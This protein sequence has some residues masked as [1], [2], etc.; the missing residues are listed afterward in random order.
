MKKPTFEEEY[1]VHLLHP[2]AQDAQE[3]K[4]D[5]SLNPISTEASNNTVLVQAA[6]HHKLGS[7]EATNLLLKVLGARSPRPSCQQIWHLMKTFLRD[8]DFLLHFYMAEGMSK[9]LWGS[10]IRTLVL[11]RKMKPPWPN[12]L[13]NASNYHHLGDQDS[14]YKWIMEIPM[15]RSW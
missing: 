4:S 11:F 5:I 2:T 7:W 3:R 10:F 8:G 13:P 6:K 1:Q 12:H 15:F 9:L 14:T